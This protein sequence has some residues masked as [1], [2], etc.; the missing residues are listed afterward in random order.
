MTAAIHPLQLED[1]VEVSHVS[2]RLALGVLWIDAL[3]RLPASGNLASDLETIGNRDCPLRFDL[4]PQSRHALPYAGRLARILVIAANEKDTTPPATPA[5]DQTRFA[6]RCFARRNLKA[7]SYNTENDPRHYVPR[8]LALIPVQTDG[9]PTATTANI[10]RAW[11]WPGAAFPLSANATVIRGRI[12]RGASMANASSVAWA[13]IV[14][15]QPGAAPAD[16]SAETQI[17]WAHGDDRGEFLVVLGAQAIP[18]G[19]VLPQTVQ[20]RVWIFLPPSDALD[21]ADPLA[22]LPLEQAGSDAIN[23]VLRGTEAP[24]T[25]IRQAPLDVTLK[26]GEALVMDDAALLFS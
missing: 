13:R 22:S 23:D 9:F 21:P 17:G 25:Y 19:A 6:L 2:H 11:L 4:H 3:T 7:D 24:A 26:P 15:T 18:G 1:T 16:F 5:D 12:R 20:L 8:R 10:R 14:V